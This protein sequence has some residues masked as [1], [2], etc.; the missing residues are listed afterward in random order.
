[1]QFLLCLLVYLC[2]ISIPTDTRDAFSLSSPGDFEPPN[3]RS[4]ISQAEELPLQQAAISPADVQHKG[5]N[6]ND[7]TARPRS[8][9]H[10]TS[11][12]RYQRSDATERQQGASHQESNDLMTEV[13]FLMKEMPSLQ[14]MVTNHNW[15]ELQDNIYI[16]YHE[17]GNSAYGNVCDFGVAG[18]LMNGQAF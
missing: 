17:T 13:A 1:M 18:G 14:D 3:K 15:N 6:H 2:S 16:P 9:N 8:G 12:I 4:R 7:K 10:Y 11:V 5:L